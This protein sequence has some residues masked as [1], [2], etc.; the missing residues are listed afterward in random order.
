MLQSSNNNKAFAST[1]AF[2]MFFPYLS[3]QG[4]FKLQNQ[5]HI[6]VLPVHFRMEPKR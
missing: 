5:H 4:S 6:I 2:F 3:G 1:F